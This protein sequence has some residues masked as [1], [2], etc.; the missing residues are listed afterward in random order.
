MMKLPQKA[1]WSG[2]EARKII[3]TEALE[4]HEG[5]FLAIHTPLRDFAVSGSRSNEIKTADEQAVL[6]GLSAPDQRHV[7]CVVQGE[8][9]S[10]K[11]HLI[12]WLSVNWSAKSDVKL[13]LQRADGSLEGALRQLQDHLPPEFKE[14]FENIGQR[15]RATDEGRA[16]LFLTHLAVS[17]D[18]THFDPPLSDVE[19][20]RSNLPHQLV[21]HMS[22]QENWKGPARI[23]SLLE[24][25][26]SEGNKNERNSETASFDL[27]DIE[28]LAEALHAVAGT[29]IRVAAE[30]LAKRLIHEAETIR[31]YRENGWTADEIQNSDAAVPVSRLMADALN[32]RRND[33]VQNLIGVSAEGLKKLFRQ[34]RERLALQKKRLVLLLEDITS[35]EGIDDSLIDV[36]VLNA[37]TRVSGNKSDLCPLISVVGVTPKYYD[38]LPGNYIGRITHEINLGKVVQEG[39]LSDV[40]TLR[41]REDREGFVARYLAAIRNGEKALDTWRERRRNDHRSVVAN[42]CDDCPVR[43]GCHE[44]F[45]AHQGIGFYPFTS[46]ALERMFHAL[47]DNDKG[48]T[49]KTPRGILQGMLSPCLSRS[50]ALEDAEFPTALLE[51]T[52]LVPESRRLSA[53]LQE[54]VELKVQKQDAPRMRRTLSYWGNKESANTTS[55]KEHAAFAG[56]PRPIFEAFQLPWIGSETV[57]EVV[58]LPPTPLPPPPEPPTA[59][60]KPTKKS[61]EPKPTTPLPPRLTPK[62]KSELEKQLEEI[63]SWADKGTLEPASHWNKVIF[64]VLQ[65]IDSRRLKLTPYVVEKILTA[66]R[67]K[68]EGTA[69]SNR[70]YLMVGPN[71]IVRKG[72]EAKVTLQHNRTGLSASDLDFHYQNLASM[73]RFFECELDAYADRRLSKLAD[74]ERWNPVPLIVQ[75]LLARAWLLGTTT[76]QGPVSQQLKVLL[77]D[78]PDSAMGASVRS[79]LWLNFLN[80]TDALQSD[81][82][83]AARKALGTPQ[84]KSR[85]FGLADVSA[86]AGAI[87][88]LRSNL[89]FDPAPPTRFETH[90]DEFDAARDLVSTFD[91]NLALVVRNERD[92][93]GDRAKYLKNAL[94]GRSIRA[95][96]K[97]V[98][99]AVTSVSGY[100]QTAAPDRVAHWKREYARLLPRLTGKADEVENLL[101]TFEQ[102]ELPPREPAQL[103]WLATAPVQDLYDFYTLAKVADD[104]T[105]VLLKPVSDC[106][107]D[108]TGSGSL[109]EVRNAGHGLNNAIVQAIGTPS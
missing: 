72:L 40:A 28:S 104:T 75:I 49:W 101:E 80:R 108:G 76:P 14:L 45:G 46:D 96:F 52:A 11:S 58:Q 86:A 88:R 22:V 97:R 39:S 41:S 17:L 15:H 6:E 60:S 20:C 5:V 34:V 54:L 90:I 36:L 83:E 3:S 32:R 100:L 105:T 35:W 27:F 106:I 2:E 53:R 78:E 73:E 71:P 87:V 7:F 74:G 95:H 25:K 37:D 43:D 65:T 56:V 30:K 48:L 68:A 24:G 93:V 67:V 77:S 94:L 70:S 57:D 50:E 103:G 64:D 21:G 42:K 4:G 89:K 51:T 10:G 29:G 26:N 18:P 38:K 66:E 82:R 23:L 1:C 98:D 81:L 109:D 16:K 63:R 44:A 62:K 85:G 47:N 107:R 84:G 31:E 19:W 92:R 61:V 9:G 91:Q 33:A 13:L 69:P 12:R 59:V 99:D 8:P 102:N 55:D 79:D